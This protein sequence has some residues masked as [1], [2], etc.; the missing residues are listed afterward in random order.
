[1]IKIYD[2]TG[3]QLDHSQ[4]RYLNVKNTIE[5]LIKNRVIPILNENDT[6]SF[7]EITVGD[8]DQLA[9]MTAQMID[10]DVLLMLTET[11]GLYDKNPKDKSAQHI[12]HVEFDKKFVD[13]SLRELSASGRGGMKTKLEAV[14]KLTPIG[15]P[16]I[17]ASY[18]ASSPILRGLTENS[19]TFFTFNQQ[20]LKSRRKSWILTTN[21]TNSW[22]RVDNGAFL[23][24]SKEASLLPS[25]IMEIGGKFKRGD[26]IGIKHSGNIFAVGLTEY[27][28][29]D[30]SKIIGKQS[31]E[32]Q[33]ILG[34]CP[35]M[36][37]IHRNN[38]VLK[39][40]S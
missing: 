37:V 25:G 38:L 33:N 12:P 28:S 23:A 2:F 27:D 30:I 11:D 8:N 29:R 9:A 3:K 32:I 6:V 40:H 5:V 4:T 10:A 13:I 1:M 31:S 7:D 20:A 35:S 21:K 36:V 16:V 15:I 18:T 26:C 22:I 34:H 39:E 19:G 24:L 17:I 14:R